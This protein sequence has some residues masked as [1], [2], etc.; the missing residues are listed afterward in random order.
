MFKG[1]FDLN[2]PFMRFLSLVGDLILI[3]LM[4][5]LCCLPVITAGASACAMYTVTMQKVRKEDLSDGVAGPFFA[6][7]KANFKKG[8]LIWIFYVLVGAAIAIN[9][10]LMLGAGEEYSQFMKVLWIIL[11]ILYTASVSW[12]FAVQARFENGVKETIKNSLILALAHPLSSVRV[13]I[14]TAFPFVLLL[15][16]TYYFL[17]SSAIWLMIGFSLL[18]YLNSMSF[19]GVFSGLEPDTQ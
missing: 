11:L 2:S 12:V 7:F 9:R 3:N 19:V 8:T 6:A 14:C 4:F 18:A 5:I 17:Y 15:Y 16:K 1:L 13:M 10:W